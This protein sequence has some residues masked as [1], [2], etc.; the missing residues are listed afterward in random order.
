MK[1]LVVRAVEDAR[2]TAARLAAAG[3]EALIAPVLEIRPIDADI[4]QVDFGGVVATSAH[5]FET[6][7]IPQRLK[8]LPLFVVG[9][10]A[11]EA[12]RLAGF[13]TPRAV[14]ENA[15]ALVAD[16]E[17]AADVGDPLLYLAGRDRK[18]DLETALDGRRGL[19]VVEVYAAEPGENL[20]DAAA[21]ALVG[22]RLDAALHYSRRSS[23]IFAD[24]A[25]AAGCAPHLAGLRHI[26]IS[27]DAAAP[28]RDLGLEVATAAR[29]DEE[30][31]FD[32]LNRLR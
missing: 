8:S 11:A 21:R 26:A 29:P 9:A 16:L 3:H 23:A 18:P 14:A 20:P 15:R 32:A 25:S 17:R 31:M 5:A 1:V 10:R 22:G 6:D 19:T 28:L 12:A 2:R 27:Q 7:A 13:S 30:S 24:L 4:P